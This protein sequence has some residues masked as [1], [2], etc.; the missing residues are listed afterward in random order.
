MFLEVACGYRPPVMENQREEKTK[1]EMA[2]GV[3]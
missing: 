1:N 3:I 2:A